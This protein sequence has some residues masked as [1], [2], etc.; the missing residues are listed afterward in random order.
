MFNLLDIILFIPFMS[1]FTKFLESWVS[2]DQQSTC[3]YISNVPSN[4]TDVALEALAKECLHLIHVVARLSLRFLALDP[5]SSSMNRLKFDHHESPTKILNMHK[6]AHYESIKLLKE[7]LLTI[8]WKCS[9]NTE[10][11]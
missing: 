11:L 7:K 2:N 3:Y 5:S 9:Y 8:A 1:L 6:L 10:I 4:I